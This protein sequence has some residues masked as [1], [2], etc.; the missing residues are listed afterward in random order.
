MLLNQLKLKAEMGY[1]GDSVANDASLPPG[2]FG[3]TKA[4]FGGSSGGGGSQDIMGGIFG[5]LSND[6]NPEFNPFEVM[7]VNPFMMAAMDLD[8][9]ATGQ[10]TA[11]AAGLESM[12]QGLTGQKLQF[13][14]PAEGSGNNVFAMLGGDVSSPRNAPGPGPFPAPHNPGIQSG[15]FNHSNH[16]PDYHQG[17]YSPG[18]ISPQMNMQAGTA[19]S[20]G[21]FNSNMGM[22][23]PPQYG[24]PQ[25]MTSPPLLPQGFT[26]PR[27]DMVRPPPI[28]QYQGQG[29]GY[30]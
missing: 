23:F 1:T 25:H 9:R 17:V 7:D 20:L 22:P 30:Y 24:G 28:N 21:M 16:Q 13:S 5:L 14:S 26:D 4:L 27:M 29:H 8:I 15:I 11:E 19:G 12:M 18:E 2:F 6:K 10:N 3:D